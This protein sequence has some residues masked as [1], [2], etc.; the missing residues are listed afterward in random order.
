MI[1]L[2]IMLVHIDMSSANKNKSQK[3]T[4][5]V[6]F[7]N[8]QIY[9]DSIYWSEI[10]NLQSAS[11]RHCQMAYLHSGYRKIFQYYNLLLLKYN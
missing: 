3:V 6:D 10:W 1:P 9:L 5:F 2:I 4:E 7:E 11:I 8:L